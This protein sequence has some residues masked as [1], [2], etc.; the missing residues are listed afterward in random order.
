MSTLEIYYLKNPG[1]MG[2]VLIIKILEERNQTLCLRPYG[3]QRCWESLASGGEKKGI[4]FRFRR[5][6]FQP[7]FTSIVR[8]KYTK[9]RVIVE[10][11]NS[12]VK[13]PIEWIL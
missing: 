11:R 12:E 10:R 2:H 6:V 13:I 4:G 3:N 1:T 5:S 9:I 7:V 8:G